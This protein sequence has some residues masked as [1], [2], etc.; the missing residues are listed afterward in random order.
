MLNFFT[1]IFQSA[2]QRRLKD[3]QKIVSKITE[4]ESDIANLSEEKFKSLFFE[5]DADQNKIVEVFAAVREAAKRAI[6]LRHFDCQ[7]VGGLVLNGGNIAEMKTGEGKTLVATLPAVLNALNHKKVYVVTVNDYLAERDAEWMR[8]VYEYFGLSV[9]F[10]TSSQSFQDK[11]ATYDCNIIYCT[12]SELGFDYLRDNMVLFK[13]QK[14]QKELNFAIIDE[15]DSILIDEARTPLIISGAT[16]DDASA[17]PVFLKLLPQL[18]RQMREGTEEEP[19][20]DSEKGDFLIDEKIRSVD[21][22]DNGFEKVEN[23]L[24]DRGMIKPDESLYTTNNLKFLKYIQATLKANLLFEKN[25]HYVVESGKV[26]LIDDN[27]GRKLPGRRISE[28]VHQALECKEK[29]GIQQETQTLASTT[30]QNFFRLFDKI[31]GMTGTADTEAAEFKQIYNMDVV[32][33]PTNQPM[34]RNDV[35]DVVY[36]NEED[37]FQALIK[38]IKTIHNKKA[39]ILVGT[40]SIESSEK[41]SKRLKKEGVRHQVLN[42]KY[43]EKEA[44]IIAEAGRPGAITIA[45]NMAGRGT[46]IVLGGRNDNDQDWQQK[47]EEVLNAGG[48]HVIGTERHESRRIDNQLRGRSGR[49]G[50]PG[51]S[52]FFLSLDDTVLRLFIDENRKQLFSRLSDGMD[53]SSIEHPLLN[54]AI[55]NAQKKIEGRNFEIRKQILEFDDVSNDQRLT[56]YELRNYYLDEND[57]SDLIKEYIENFLEKTTDKILPE[58]QAGNWNFDEL[59]NSLQASLTIAPDFKNLDKANMSFG[60]VMDFLNE[61][62]LNFYHDKFE[63][64]GN[65][66]QELERQIAIQVLDACWKRHLQNV[67]SLRANIG[68]RAYAQRNPIN[69]FKRESFEMFDAMIESFKDDSVR[70]LFNIKIQTMSKQEF[71]QQKQQRLQQNQKSK[72][73]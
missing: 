61:F 3:Y 30:Y 35:N 26:V 54:G 14:S 10:L 4:Q 59:A 24:A 36:V 20:T 44:G 11:Q 45:T 47:H 60:K 2:N 49:Q 39:P 57:P 5:G 9:G 73:E 67:D 15:V 18:K 51:Y 29:V 27:T 34:V 70:I 52:K 19:L 63:K 16:D 25:V 31:S 66:K 65:K 46:D 7:L 1:R 12:S 55:A 40:A 72:T 42:A 71:E 21:L 53:D 62:Y 38:E 37:K 43:H 41:L 33:I 50:D 64:L 23:F 68:L 56:V 28:G 58:D 48:L 6:G 32:V 17:Y 69:E 8:P 22:T 13:N